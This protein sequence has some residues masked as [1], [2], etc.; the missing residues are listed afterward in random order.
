[1]TPALTPL[2]E[3]TANS[4]RPG[5][6][7]M[8]EAARTAFVA[9]G[10]AAVSTQETADEVGVTKAS[11]YYHF[12]DKEALFGEAFVDE[13]ERICAGI[14]DALASAQTLAAQIET[15]ARFLLATSGLEFARL[16]ADL[17]RYV[18]LEHRR[19]LIERA[20]RPRE[21]VRQAFAAAL[22]RGEIRAVDLEV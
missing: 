11:L 21:I 19:A 10:Y 18:S 20:P 3:E 9:R 7:R 4:A 13:M 5:R 1:M 22:E 8:L 17:D 12:R 2:I 16:V 14:A 6:T 15:L